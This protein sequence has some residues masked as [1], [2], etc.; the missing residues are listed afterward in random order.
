LKEPTKPLYGFGGKRIE[1]S[2]V[3][4]LPISFGTPQNPRTKYITFIVVDMLYLYNV[5]FGQGLLNTFEGAL[6]SGYLCLKIPTTFRVISI[7][8]SQKDARNIEQGFTPDHKNVHFLR[9]E[10]RQYQQSAYPLK[11]EALVE[12]K[13]AIEADG[14]FKK[15]PL[16][17]MLPDR[18]VCLGTETDLEEQAEL[19]GFLD[20]N[21]NVFAW[22][23]IDLM[24]VSRDI[25]EH[26][27][28][29]SPNV[30]PRKQKLQKMS[31]EKV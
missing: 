19:L 21:S 3:I 23:T 22:S 20:K 5:I 31:E 4:T 26:R 16:G 2:R 28:Q 12:F 17:H 7:F 30:K 13:K 18:A 10:S 14:D 15:V 24:G 11:A 1:S 25:I 8:N 9:E 6:H 27:L 29:L